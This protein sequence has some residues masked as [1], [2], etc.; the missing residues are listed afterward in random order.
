MAYDGN[1]PME[2]DDLFELDPLLKQ[3]ALSAA[4]QQN[5][6]LTMPSSGSVLPPAAQAQAPQPVQQ[7]QPQSMPPAQPRA[8]GATGLPQAVAASQPGGVED[9][10]RQILERM[11]KP[12]DPQSYMQ[13]A[14][15]RATRAGRN[16]AL[17]LTLSAM[18]GESLS[19]VGKD[20]LHQGL[21]ESGDYEV[22]GGW[23]SVSPTGVFTPNKSK[24]DEAELNKLVTMLGIEERAQ[25]TRDTARERREDR[26][27]TQA[28]I[29]AQ[30]AETNA[31]AQSAQDMT[32]GQNRFN[33]ENKLRDDFNQVT[34][35]TRD[36]IETSRVL[37]SIPN[38]GKLSP[39]QQQ[40]MIIML[41]KFQDPGS[42][43]R[44]GEFDRVKFAQ[45]ILQK[46][47]NV[48]AM[49]QSGQQLSPA[50]QKDLMQVI[51]IY[52]Q[53]AE[54]TMKSFAGDYIT[55]A[56]ANDLR[57]E[58]VV[59][60]RRWHPSKRPGGDA[61]PGGRGTADSPLVVQPAAPGGTAAPA[62]RPSPL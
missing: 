9:L 57:P 41:N 61:Q 5:P 55:N 33:N 35:N 32:R 25:T 38:N 43:V 13:Q 17:G 7:P 36:V 48:P 24:Q 3:R 54:Q 21:K 18:G 47:G 42:V 50:L 39:L 10:R 53:A 15:E 59:T 16:S 8:A 11:G 56:Q 44:E 46:W 27:L 52:R 40:S 28:G 26:K 34:K 1:V 60:D 19:P 6:A 23:G 31:R 12:P 62:A 29:D 37:D 20:M 49:I 45:G 2:G 30:R 51:G 22:P 4:V 14:Q 58:Q